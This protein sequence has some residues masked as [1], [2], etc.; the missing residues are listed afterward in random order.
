MGVLVLNKTSYGEYDK[1]THT[2]FNSLSLNLS[3]GELAIKI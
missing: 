3:Q 2:P 1:K